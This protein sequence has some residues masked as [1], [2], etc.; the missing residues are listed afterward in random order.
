[1]CCFVVVVLRGQTAN[2][3]DA[4]YEARNFFGTT[5]PDRESRDPMRPGSKKIKNFRFFYFLCFK[6]KSMF[7]FILYDCLIV[8][9]WK[10]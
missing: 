6:K 10:F 8:L 2:L 1:M 7:F 9:V 4:G 3:P 5:K